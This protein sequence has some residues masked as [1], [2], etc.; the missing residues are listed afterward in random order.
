MQSVGVLHI[1]AHLGQAANSRERADLRVL[2]IEVGRMRLR[3]FD[4]RLS[5]MQSCE[6]L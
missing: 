6:F 3:R 1:G 2:W 5:R 4:L